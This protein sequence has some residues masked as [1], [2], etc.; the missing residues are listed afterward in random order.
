[1]QKATAIAHPIQGLIKYHGMKD[2]KLRLPYHDSISVCMQ[3]LATITTVEADSALREDIYLI[4]DKQPEKR[5]KERMKDII[6]RIREL[7]NQ[8][9]KVKAISKN[10]IGELTHSYQLGKGLGYSASAGAALAMAG[11]KAFE[12]E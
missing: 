10:I 2:H 6:D 7:A 3:E 4:N 8:D 5:E 11:A 12:L 1:M 9:I